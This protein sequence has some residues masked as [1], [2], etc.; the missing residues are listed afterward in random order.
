MAKLLDELE[1]FDKQTNCVQAIIETP[2]GSRNKYS[3]DTRRGIFTLKK[4]LPAGHSFPFDFG[5]V[6]GTLGEDGD[7]LDIL[8]LMEETV[9]QGV[10]VLTRLVAV[11]E[12]VQTENGEAKR[13]D[14][15]IGVSAA[16]HDYKAVK[17]LDQLS[18]T[19]GEEIEHFFI[20][21]N[22]MLG[23]N[24]KPLKR[25]GAQRAR[26]IIEGGVK[27]ARSG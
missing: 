17:S 19:L 13:N 3:Y 10:M 6:P 23:R 18:P 24:F 14:R 15:L 20:S 2:R 26:E 5:F 16:S 8:V 7:A 21:Y 12:A 25:V 11:I 4:V 1:P 9:P 27:L 22:E